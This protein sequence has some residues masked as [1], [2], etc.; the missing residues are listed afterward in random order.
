MTIDTQ[1]FSFNAA[2]KPIIL[3]NFFIFYAAV[4]PEF[5]KK[6]KKLKI[7]FKIFLNFLIQCFNSGF[8]AALKPEILEKI[9]KLGLR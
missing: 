5:G 7:I 4:K 8:T 1:I 6:F 2:L 9:K 3:S